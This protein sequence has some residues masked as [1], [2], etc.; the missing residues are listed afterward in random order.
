M[1]ASSHNLRTDKFNCSTVS[2]CFYIVWLAIQA[3]WIPQLRATSNPPFAI[4]SICFLSSCTLLSFVSVCCPVSCSAVVEKRLRPTAACVPFVHPPVM[5]HIINRFPALLVF[6]FALCLGHCSSPEIDFG[7]G[8]VRHWEMPDPDKLMRQELHLTHRNRFVRTVKQWLLDCGATQVTTHEERNAIVFF[9]PISQ[10]ER[11]FSI[12]LSQF[13]NVGSGEVVISTRDYYQVPDTV[14]PYVARITGLPGAPH[15]PK[16]EPLFAGIRDMFS[17]AMDL[18]SHAEALLCTL[19]VGILSL[20]IGAVRW[21]SCTREQPSPTSPVAEAES[22]KCLVSDAQ[23]GKARQRSKRKAEKAKQKLVSQAVET[24]L[25]PAEKDQENQCNNPSDGSRQVAE[26]REVEKELTAL[27]SPM[28]TAEVA[29]EVRIMQEGE[30]HITRPIRA[31]A[32]RQSHIQKSRA[33][34]SPKNV[35][36]AMKVEA[37]VQGGAHPDKKHTA[38]VEVF[39]ASKRIDLPMQSYF[40]QAESA[41]PSAPISGLER[42]SQSVRDSGKHTTNVEVFS[43]SKRIDL[44]MQSYFIQAE[45]AAPSAPISG[46]ERSSQS[47]RDSELEQQSQPKP[48]CLIHSPHIS[49]SRCP[50]HS[51]VHTTRQSPLHSPC[52]G[53]LHEGGTDLGRVAAVESC[54]AGPKLAE[55]G[56][57]D[58]LDS[59]DS[60]NPH[61]SESLFRGSLRDSTVTTPRDTERDMTL[62]TT[63]TIPD[64]D[65]GSKSFSKSW[66]DMMEEELGD[67]DLE[68]HEIAEIESHGLTY[69]VASTY[70]VGAP[71]IQP[72]GAFLGKAGRCHTVRF[73]DLARV[74]GSG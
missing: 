51:A 66:Y 68:W 15:P 65:S 24:K 69:P 5:K 11:T 59:E 47:V 37:V 2:S 56:T 8:W 36:K 27:Q 26:S 9:M 34:E 17:T 14:E 49:P 64:D 22:Q 50:T 32:R 29:R 7:E 38:N 42:S 73:E 52:H 33:A 21:R 41:A 74:V 46:L 13:M 35:P 58:L 6:G 62:S 12:Q 54:T 25:F 39:S 45:F 3:R 23:K 60:Y 1:L 43:T 20:I 61:D 72:R 48:H 40:I 55:L 19:V 70:P 53:L 10:L 30:Q 4:R 31:T 63:S 71:Y 28:V 18:H 44:P 57:V 16:P 67:E